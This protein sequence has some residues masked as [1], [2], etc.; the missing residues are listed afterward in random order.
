M[1]W[2]VQHFPSLES[3]KSVEH[4]WSAEQIVPESSG[5]KYS[6]VVTLLSGKET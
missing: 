3:I 2:P 5:Q 6:G 1:H 4:V